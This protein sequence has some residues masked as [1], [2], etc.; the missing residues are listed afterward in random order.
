MRR[1][2]GKDEGRDN[3]LDPTMKEHEE[4]RGKS[5]GAVLD[6]EKTDEPADPVD[7][8]LGEQKTTA[9]GSNARKSGQRGNDD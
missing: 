7:Q 4:A 2:S 8:H 9:M 6:R 1:N 3:L 5:G